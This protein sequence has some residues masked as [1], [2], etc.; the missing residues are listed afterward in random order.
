MCSGLQLTNFRTMRHKYNTWKHYSVVCMYT[1][2]SQKNQIGFVSTSAELSK[3]C[4]AF[5]AIYLAF[6]LAMG[7]LYYYLRNYTIQR[8]IYPS[9]CNQE[10]QS[11]NIYMT[12]SSRLTNITACI[13]S[14]LSAMLGNNTGREWQKEKTCGV[15]Q[16]ISSVLGRLLS[17]NKMMLTQSLFRMA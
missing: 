5:L 17:I 16:T 15:V 7:F 14:A 4:T 9:F 8:H 11:H 12:F 6:L 3:A 1:Y 2:G 13:H 10:R